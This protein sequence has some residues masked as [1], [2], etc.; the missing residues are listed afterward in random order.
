MEYVYSVNGDMRCDIADSSKF[1]KT[2]ISDYDNFVCRYFVVMHCQIKDH[3]G[4]WGKEYKSY[5]GFVS[6]D[7]TIEQIERVINYG[8]KAYQ[9][10]S[11]CKVEPETHP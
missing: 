5:C 1:H 9:L 10:I 6:E 8:S 2:K 4:N 7:E 11:F 3:R